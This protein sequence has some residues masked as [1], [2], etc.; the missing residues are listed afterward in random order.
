MKIKKIIKYI[1]PFGL[2]VLLKKI[3]SKIPLNL[4]FKIIEN[5]IKDDHLFCISIIKSNETN[6]I[7]QIKRE[8]IIHPL[9]LRNNTSDVFVY[10]HVFEEYIY[11]FNVRSEPKFIIDAGANIGIVTIFFANKYKNAKI[12]A[13][14]PEDKNYELLVKNTENYSNI[15]T[16]KSALWN[17]CRE[18]FLFDCDSNYGFQV[19]IEK[20]YSKDIKQLIKTI[21]ISKI[22]EDFNIDS[23]DILKIDIE[24]SEKEVFE[25]NNDF[26]KKTNCI[27]IELHERIKKGCNKALFK[28]VKM[29]ENIGLRNDNIFL[30][31]NNYIKM[32]S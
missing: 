18:I 30:S 32:L 25:T 5:D 15:T 11:N 17:D 26:I 9:Y 23:I 27:I 3:I 14:E 19:G 28:N 29:F 1:I 10:K 4:N 22:M 31:R 6:E 2:F 8:G 24:G 13:I 7:L 12:I 20:T 21:S 16:I